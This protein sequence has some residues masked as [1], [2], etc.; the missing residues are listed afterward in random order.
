MYVKKGLTT[1]IGK[2][3]ELLSSVVR[4]QRRNIDHIA[5]SKNSMELTP[6]VIST[7]ETFEILQNYQTIEDL[8]TSALAVH[9]QR[10]SKEY[11]DEAADYILAH[12]AYKKSTIAFLSRCLDYLAVS[13]DLEKYLSPLSVYRIPTMEAIFAST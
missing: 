11:T 6:T 12:R 13:H 4:Q 7:I 5:I 9:L 10:F 2:R 8:N 3:V 1:Q